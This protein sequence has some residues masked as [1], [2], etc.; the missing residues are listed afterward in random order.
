[1]YDYIYPI[2]PMSK[3]NANDAERLVTIL[4]HYL[5]SN[6][7]IKRANIT[8]E[9]EVRFGTRGIKR[10]LKIDYDNIVQKLFALGFKMEGAGAGAAAPDTTGTYY[11]RINSE[12]DDPKT[13]ERK[14]SRNVRTEIA[15]LELIQEYCRAQNI[16]KLLALPSTRHDKI[17]ITKK[18]FVDRDTMGDVI[19]P[20]FNYSISYKREQ[21]FSI[22]SQIGASIISGWSK[23]KKTFRY[24]N[25]VRFYH[26][27]YPIFVDLS[28]VKHSKNMTPQMTVE[29]AELFKMPEKYEVE[30]EINNDAMQGIDGEYLMSSL[31]K[32]IRIILSALQGTN[33]PISYKKQEEVLNSYMKLIHGPEYEPRKTITPNYFLGPST[34]TLQLNNIVVPT[35]ND[36]SPNIRNNYTVTEKADGVRKLLYIDHTGAIYFID[37]NMNVIFTGAHSKKTDTFQTIIDGEHIL[38]DKNGKYINRFAAFD[39][40][41]DHGLNVRE[42]P[43]YIPA[44]AAD[45]ETQSAAETEKKGGDG[46]AA[47]AEGGAAKDKII[48]RLVRLQKQIKLLQTGTAAAATTAAPET[49]CDVEFVAKDFYYGG[50]N[51]FAKCKIILDKEKDGLF[52]YTIDG[53]IF[54]PANMAVGGTPEN[55]NTSPN[56]KKAWIYSMKWKPPQY[57]TIDF[58]VSFKKDKSTG[59][60][61]IGYIFQD[62]QNMVS[63]E[64]PQYKTLILHCGYDPKSNGYIN[65]W[66]MVIEGERPK[67]DGDGDDSDRN[68]KPVV[69]QPTDPYDKNACFCNVELTGKDKVMLTEENEV[70]EEE[71]IVEFRYNLGAKEG[72]NWVPMRVRYD[73]TSELRS[74]GNNFG[75]VY[76]AANSNWYSIHHPI[77]DTMICTGDGVPTSVDDYVYYAAAVDQKRAETQTYGLR[78][79]HN[80]CKKKL[81]E[82]VAREGDTL[83][84]YAVG[85]GGDMQK[86]YDVKLGF[87]FGVDLHKDNIENSLN[88]ACAR[89]L[90]LWKTKRR[91]FNAMFVN[92]NSTLNIRTGEAMVTEKDKQ[93]TRA[94]FGAGEKDREK[95][96]KGVYDVYGAAVDGFQI[97]SCQ[98]A[99]HYFF[100]NAKTLHNFLVNLSETIKV[101][102][103]FI[104][105]CYDG[106]EVFRALKNSFLDESITIFS[107][108]GTKI[109][110]IT[111]KFDFTSFP[112][113]E[114]SVGYGIDVYQESI[115]KVLREYLVKFPYFVQ[116]MET[117]GFTLDKENK[118]IRGGTEMF[119]ALYGRMKTDKTFMTEPEKRISFFN[120]AFVFRKVFDVDAKKLARTL[121]RSARENEEIEMELREA[122]SPA[123]APAARTEPAPAQET[124]AAPPKKMR[125]RKNVT[126][127]QKVVI[128]QYS[129]VL[130]TPPAAV[131]AAAPEPA[132]VPAPEPAAPEKPKKK[133][134]IRKAPKAPEPEPEP[135][136]EEKKQAPEPAAAPPKKRCPNGTR[137]NPKTGECEPVAKK[138]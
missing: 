85:K 48:P 97:G 90:D 49:R 124:E 115:N 7:H 43:F 120:R 134:V 131:A 76:N 73:K 27:D 58:M 79:F 51:I 4:E 15:G 34:V 99:L 20:E 92:G 88:G 56:M 50:A 123:A 11:L 64:L 119:S 36:I 122:L 138:K 110:E 24:I 130:E 117:Y 83:I 29:E 118:I 105:T 98:F 12:F 94:V 116:L 75:N 108:N 63:P 22:N 62:G 91:V 137:R 5:A 23:Y 84:D 129:P 72:W 114:L 18:D 66:H 13:G 78:N 70:I 31:R 81:F 55:K 68:Y 21:D 6:P 47:A 8:N 107:N 74:T 54:T 82:S 69:F 30:L 61:E 135:E 101:G 113:D 102:G 14:F 19:F 42:Q 104:G 52:P 87:V 128:A 1:M 93:I 67:R 10:I 17:K 37:M 65:P 16:Q 3:D 109:C 127:K 60:D 28:I 95:L 80:L 89:Y 25:R 125:I 77:T 53:L 121:L 45:E 86:W 38:H 111:K 41:Y 40:Y 2:I 132:P 103:V 106:D 71:M 33:T 9:V 57:N 59:Q 126:R 133:I 136:P 35:A 46:S 44:A 96:G 39:I 32:C 112:D 100:E 26:D